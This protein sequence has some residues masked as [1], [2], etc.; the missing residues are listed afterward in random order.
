MLFGKSHF[1][2]SQSFV[3]HD[4]K[5]EKFTLFGNSPMG[6]SE[7]AIPRQEVFQ[8]MENSTQ[9]QTHCTDVG[10]IKCW[11]QRAGHVFLEGPDE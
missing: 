9:S 5:Y 1:D 10:L 2:A 6:L 11:A 7:T 8:L 4:S 3:N